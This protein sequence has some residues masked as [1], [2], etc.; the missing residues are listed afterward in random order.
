LWGKVRAGG[1][2]EKH[3]FFLTG[4][5][6]EQTGG[7]LAGSGGLAG[8]SEHSGDRGEGQNGEED[9]GVRFTSSPWAVVAHEGRSTVAAIC[10][11]GV[12]TVYIR[13]KLHMDLQA[14]KSPVVVKGPFFP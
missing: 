1:L 14:D 11:R 6:G 7:G 13:I 2:W 12:L 9:E 5:R 10:G 4:N 8:A 3:P